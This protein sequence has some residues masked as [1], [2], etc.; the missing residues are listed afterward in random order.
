MELLVDGHHGIYVPQEFAKS[1]NMRAWHVDPEDEKILLEG[2][3]H[4]DY[5]EA[6][7]S[8]LQNAYYTAKNGEQY[9]LFEDS[10]DLFAVS[11]DEDLEGY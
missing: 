1:F 6:W 2:P 4:P 11:E 8:V 3:Y 5:W 7:D 10:G 9:Y